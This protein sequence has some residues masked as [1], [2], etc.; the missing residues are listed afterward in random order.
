M[1][2][3]K[4]E[5]RN[6]SAMAHAIHEPFESIFMCVRPAALRG[7]FALPEP[8]P[9]LMSGGAP[10]GRS[11]VSELESFCSEQ[12]L[13]VVKVDG[14]WFVMMDGGWFVRMDGGW[15]AMSRPRPLKKRRT[16]FRL[17][18]ESDGGST[19][20]AWEPAAW[21]PATWEPAAWEPAACCLSS[22][23]NSVISRGCDGV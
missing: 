7:V 2:A 12:L 1:I 5:R 21:E 15:A 22:H 10:Q 3:E 4:N 19:R 8:E 16:E 20:A 9:V 14:G 13:C 6:A 17:Q 18:S 11:K 23:A